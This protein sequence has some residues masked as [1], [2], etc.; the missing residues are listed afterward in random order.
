MIIDTRR[1]HLSSLANE[2]KTWAGGQWRT[3]SVTSIH[4]KPLL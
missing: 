3:L 2:A 4:L 1:T